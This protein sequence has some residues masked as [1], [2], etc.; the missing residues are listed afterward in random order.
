[1][2]TD[3]RTHRQVTDTDELPTWMPKTDAYYVTR[4]CDDGRQLVII[5]IPTGKETILVSQLPKG[6]FMMSPA[7]D[8][9]LL[10]KDC[11]DPK[12][13]ND[14]YEIVEP[15]DRQSGWCNRIRFYRYDL[16]QLCPLKLF[17]INFP[18]VSRL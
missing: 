13:A 18:E 9:L 8:Y 12:E 2:I 1:M 15:D 11:E 7:E 6:Y 10:M 16:T 14:I 17:L 5:D 3:L 4:K